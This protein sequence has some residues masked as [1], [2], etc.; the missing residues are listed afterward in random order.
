MRLRFYERG[1]TPSRVFAGNFSLAVNRRD[2]S[3]D[4]RPF[5]RETRHTLVHAYRLLPAGGNRIE[6]CRSPVVIAAQQRQDQSDMSAGLATKF[7]DE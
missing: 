3:N 2:W 7:N 4:E 5:T 1:V 6:M